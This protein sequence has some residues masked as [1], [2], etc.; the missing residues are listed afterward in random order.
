MKDYKMIIL[1]RESNVPNDRNKVSLWRKILNLFS[2]PQIPIRYYYW[3]ILY[4]EQLYSFD[5]MAH[6]PRCN[7]TGIRLSKKI[8]W[9]CHECNQKVLYTEKS[10]YMMDKFW[11]ER[12]ILFIKSFAKY[13]ESNESLDI[14]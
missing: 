8:Y 6:C 12:D 1:D 13:L 3:S 9:V 5:N 11:E 10:D 7:G 4:K 14:H 2:K